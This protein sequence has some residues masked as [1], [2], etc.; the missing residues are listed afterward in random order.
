MAKGKTKKS[1]TDGEETPS[2]SG[3]IV[4]KIVTPLLIFGA[5]FG[6]NWFVPVEYPDQTASPMEDANG[7]MASKETSEANLTYEAKRPATSY[8]ITPI[9]ISVGDRGR[10]L[11]LGASLELVNGEL[12]PDDPRLRDAFMAYLRAIDPD[13]LSRPGFHSEMKRQL[14]HRARV[15]L[16][17]SHGR[18]A[19]YGVLIT[20]FYLGVK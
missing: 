11:R 14:L 1:K 5:A 9:I 7:S 10:T 6:A 16:E 18:D 15:A 17:D 20:D 8:P 13:N 12:H 2:K 4:S 19:V 3:G